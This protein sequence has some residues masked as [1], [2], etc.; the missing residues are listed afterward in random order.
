MEAGTY[1]QCE[2]CGK[3]I[4]PARLKAVPQAPFCI[5]CASE[6]EQAAR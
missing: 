2:E 5:D 3:T 6:N 4:A 1:G